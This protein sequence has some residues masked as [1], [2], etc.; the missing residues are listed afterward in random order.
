MIISRGF[1]R[2]GA[3]D[4]HYR[5]AGTGPTVVLLHDSPRSSVLYEGL[6]ATLADRF[7]VIALDTPGYGDS[8][9]LP[10]AAP[11]IGD[12]SQALAQTLDALGI[13]RAAFYG[14]HTSSKILLDFAAR[15]P[16]R[17]SLEV[18]DGL[19]IPL[20]E[21]GDAFITR[22]MRAFTVDEHGA[23]L[24]REWTR[25]LDTWRWFPWFNPVEAARMP[26]ATPSIALLHAYGLD[27]FLS[28][29]SY[30]SAYEAAMRHDPTDNIRRVTAPVVV[31]ARSDDVLFAHLDRLPKDASETVSV[32]RL[33]PDLD[34]W[35]QALGGLFADHAREVR[36]P[37]PIT[38]AAGCGRRYVDLP[39]GQILVRRQGGAGRPILVL[40][41]VPGGSAAEQETLQALAAER[42]VYALDLPGCGGSD[43]L[44][45]PSAEGYVEVLAQAIEALAL[46]R[47]DLIAEGFATPLALAL[48]ARRP[49]LVHALV[50]DGILLLDTPTREQF[51][52][53]AQISLSPER[54]GAHWLRAWRMLRDREA[55]F[56]WWSDAVDAIRHRTPD[57]DGVRLRLMT[58]DVMRQP[59][60][61]AD[62]F[63]AALDVDAIEAL[64]AVSAPILV[65]CDDGDPR[66]GG[67]AIPEARAA[68]AHLKLREGAVSARARQY[69]D[70]LA[71]EDHSGR[72]PAR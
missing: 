62:A 59:E 49:D 26:I 36:A 71:S 9:P 70:F 15:A 28:G 8:D 60:H 33:S 56:P 50:L 29:P 22:Y 25:V 6:I 45:Q 31:M 14:F 10:D 37:S 21:P 69:L 30:S 24:T 27:Y 72:T 61:W 11:G 66:Q 39:H 13:E 23:W 64:G 48:A 58:L 63:N 19:S 68:A 53:E 55:Q 46:G 7:E 34:L 54:S 47:V 3:R 20:G 40:H 51:K 52:T 65:P 18:L 38:D 4:T 43:P 57:I 42:P 12:F 1:V 44:P 5:T 35:E 67:W 41:D 32:Q 17:V 2:V 16:E